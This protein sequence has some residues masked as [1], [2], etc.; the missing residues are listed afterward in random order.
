MDLKVFVDADPDV[1]LIRRLERDIRERGRTLESVIRQY[2]EFVRPMH[3]SFVEP[4]K[5]Y[6]DVIIPR[7]GHNQPALEMLVSRIRTLIEV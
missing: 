1:R 6:A 7:G 5:R 4:T 2:L 3:L